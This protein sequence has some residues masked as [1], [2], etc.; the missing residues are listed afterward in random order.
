[1]GAGSGGECHG[2]MNSRRPEQESQ[3]FS[4]HT[5]RSVALH[6]T[7]DSDALPHSVHRP[8]RDC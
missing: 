5:P 8:A 3:P 6:T 1:M 4:S 2:I 7:D